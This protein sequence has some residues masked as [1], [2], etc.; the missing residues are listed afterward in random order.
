MDSESF[1][2]YQAPVSEVLE[3]P[4]D[5]DELRPLPWEDPE[6]FPGFWK[7]VGG[8]FRLA[9]SEPVDLFRRVPLGSDFGAPARFVVM[10]AVPILA[11]VVLFVGVAAAIGAFSG[12]GDLPVWLFPAILMGA[13][14]LLPLMYCVQMFLWGAVN[15]AC[16]WLWGGL[17]DGEPLDQTIRA[18][19]YAQG[20]LI[21]GGMI[22]LLNYAVMVVVP[23]VLGM[24]LARMHRTDT[25][26][27]ICA[28]FTPVLLCCCLYVASIATF[29][30]LGKSLH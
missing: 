27:G 5:L 24:G 13:L 21:L 15:H 6:A 25:W 9:F 19:G 7:R 20:F 8:M 28:A 30:A 23:V 10:M 4:L 26:R 12:E 22:P 3:T 14:I 2:P 1:N 18:T 11:I 16:L 17:K 29:M